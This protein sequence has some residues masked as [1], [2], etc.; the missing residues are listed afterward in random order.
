MHVVYYAIVGFDELNILSVV[1]LIYL[2]N[3]FQ[4]P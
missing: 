2:I 4:Q 3:L 1:I